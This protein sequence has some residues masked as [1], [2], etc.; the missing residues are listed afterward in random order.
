MTCQATESG[1]RVHIASKTPPHGDSAR[2][3]RRIRL[4]RTS[5]YCC[6][7]SVGVV[8]CLAAT[9]LSELAWVAAG[10]S[11]SSVSS[12]TR[13][14]RVGRQAAGEA[15]QQ[16]LDALKEFD[17]DFRAPFKLLGLKDPE[18]PKKEIRAAFKKMAKKEHPDVSDHEDAEE[19]F[20]RISMAYELLMDDG[21]RAM[22]MECMERKVDEIEDLETTSTDLDDGMEAWEQQWKE[23]EF[24]A[25]YRLVF[26]VV[27]FL[28]V[29]G[30]IWWFGFEHD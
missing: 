22:L 13:R 18:A 20:A 9:L 7:L 17:G 12:A 11:G 10:R 8:L 28:S 1:V 6:G 29:G 24:T 16:V 15:S 4:R 19:R 3:A 5:L 23:D 25:V 27:M 14:L 30:V 26:I 21:G 2:W